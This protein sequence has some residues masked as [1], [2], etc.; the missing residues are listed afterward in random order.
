M[1]RRTVSSEM[2]RGKS[3]TREVGRGNKEKT[4]EGEKKQRL[5]VELGSRPFYRLFLNGRKKEY[6]C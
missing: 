5:K 2:V 1:V 3:S 6:M 4:S